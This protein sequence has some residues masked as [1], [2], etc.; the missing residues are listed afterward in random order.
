MFM[1]YAL[2]IG[3]LITTHVILF[4]TMSEIASYI[5][6]FPLVERRITIHEFSFLLFT[7]YVDYN[8]YYL[9][10]GY[11]FYLYIIKKKQFIIIKNK[12]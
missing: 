10:I 1:T 6:T 4:L 2:F 11:I 9:Y 5:V 8:N 3:H 7:I 12:A